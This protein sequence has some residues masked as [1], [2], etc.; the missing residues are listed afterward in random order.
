MADFTSGYL[1]FKN[2]A[3]LGAAHSLAS[4]MARL[5]S[6]VHVL[7]VGF[8]VKGAWVAAWVSDASS[9]SKKTAAQIALEN[10]MECI[11]VSAATLNAMYSLCPSIGDH[12]EEAVI[13]EA[14]ELAI[15]SFLKYL[16]ACLKRNWKLLEIRLRKSGPAGIHAFLVGPSGLSLAEPNETVSVARTVLSGEY[17]RYF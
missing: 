2:V 4:Q 12:D 10:E 17:R 3:T 1:V 14:D 11:Q 16:E 13:V 6:D 7:D 8:L 9:D 5:N 15:G